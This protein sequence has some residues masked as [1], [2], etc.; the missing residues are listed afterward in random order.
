MQCLRPYALSG[1]IPRKK[2]LFLF[3]CS[4]K[5]KFSKPGRYELHHPSQSLHPYSLVIT[6]YFL[7]FLS[8]YVSLPSIVFFL[9]FHIFVP[10]GSTIS[11]ESKINE[12]GHAVNRIYLPEKQFKLGNCMQL[13]A[14]GGIC[15]TNI[16]DG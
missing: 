3:W 10:I 16:S 7:V 1:D 15:I 8:T 4:K 9:F 11:H 13:N 14:Y 12:T 2:N 5:T 6:I